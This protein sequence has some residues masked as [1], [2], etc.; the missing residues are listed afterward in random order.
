MNSVI[1]RFAPSPTGNLHIGGVRTALI[2]YIVTQQAKKEHSESKFLLRIEDTDKKRSTNE[3]I[4]NIIEGLNWLGIHYDKEPYIQ[5]KRIKRHQE[6]AYKLINQKKAYKCVCTPED[7]EKKREENKKNKINLKR[8]CETCEDN[9]KIQS[10]RE[11]YAIRIKI[12]ITEQT[13]INDL[14]QGKITVQNK[15]LDNFIILRNDGSPTYMLSVVVDDFDMGVNLI[16]R[17][18]D[19]LNNVFRQLYIYKNMS[20]SIPKY[21]HIPL[22]HGEDGKKLSKRH[23]ALNI[24]EFKE[25]GYLQESIINNLILLGWAPPEQKEIIRI[26]D[27]IKFFDIRKFS[28]SSSIFSYDKLTFFNNH[29]I[30]D[31]NN[32]VKLLNYCKKYD[33]LNYYLKTDVEKLKRIF[34]IYKKN[35]YFYKDLEKICP[36]YFEV[37]YQTKKNNLLDNS[38]N[39]LIKEFTLILEKIN[40]WEIDNLEQSIKDFIKFKKIKFIFFGK[41]L[42][43][44]LINSENGPSIKDILFILGKKNSIQRIKNYISA[45]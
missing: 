24:N 36:I 5:S 31:E 3:F 6:I 43:L 18:D 38:F 12:P 4:D 10:L 33:I 14:I 7:L 11:G 42:R 45:I 9:L 39:L 41:P 26:N 28:K 37:K 1:T 32:Y 13:Y 15:E 34:F 17:G 19:H 40:N 44:M 22:I 35:L 20:W 16:I 30:N 21:A 8:L 23:G 29:Y 2:N 25:A 27:I